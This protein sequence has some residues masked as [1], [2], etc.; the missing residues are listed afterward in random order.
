MADIHIDVIDP[1]DGAH[2]LHNRLT[3]SLHTISPQDFVDMIRIDIVDADQRILRA[4]ELPK[5]SDV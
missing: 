2:F 3:S 5:A 1:E 4:G